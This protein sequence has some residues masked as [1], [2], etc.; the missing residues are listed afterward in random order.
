M[1]HAYLM[2]PDDNMQSVFRGNV[3]SRVEP[4]ARDRAADFTR[5]TRVLSLCPPILSPSTEQ[6]SCYPPGGII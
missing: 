4:F 1:K 6:G 2:I 5:R 3:R